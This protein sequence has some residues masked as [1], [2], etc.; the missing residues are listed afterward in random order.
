[1]TEAGG[2][3]DPRQSRLTPELRAEIGRARPG[4]VAARRLASSRRPTSAPA[5]PDLVVWGTQDGLAG[6]GRRAAGARIEGARFQP[7]EYSELPQ[8]E[9]PDAFVMRPAV[10]QRG[11]LS[12]VAP[13]RDALSDG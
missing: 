8:L 4:Y 9:Q 13:R 1:V 3:G 12:A 6:R 5:L 10:H 7:F 2:R 11:Q